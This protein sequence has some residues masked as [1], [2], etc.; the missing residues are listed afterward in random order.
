MSTDA[1]PNSNYTTTFDL[2][3]FLNRTI[4]VDKP[5]EWP[6]PL[7]ARGPD[8][9]KAW[10]DLPCHEAAKDEAES[11]CHH[12]VKDEEELPCREAV[13]DVAEVPCP[14]AKSAVEDA[15]NMCMG[16]PQE[17]SDTDSVVTN[18]EKDYKGWS[19]P[20]INDIQ[21]AESRHRS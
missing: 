13:K 1:D 11:S 7:R 20:H 3:R 19:T 8:A 21:R 2:S 9:D 6:R 4:F 14:E 10:A 16:S 18:P 17:A 15:P 12:A 5:R